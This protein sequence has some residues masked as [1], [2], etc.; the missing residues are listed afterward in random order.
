MNTDGTPARGFDSRDTNKLLVDGSGG[1]LTAVVVD[2][3]E[4]AREKLRRLLVD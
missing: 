3:E 2:D 4:L 1:V